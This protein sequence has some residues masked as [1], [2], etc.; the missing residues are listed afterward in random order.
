[1]SLNVSAMSW[2]MCDDDGDDDDDDDEALQNKALQK[3]PEKL[4]IEKKTNNSN[5]QTNDS[6]GESDV[7]VVTDNQGRPSFASYF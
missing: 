6:V 3:N 5:L 1:M 4:I 2:V 7:V